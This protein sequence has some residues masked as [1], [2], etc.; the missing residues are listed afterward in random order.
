MLD[1]GR[2]LTCIFS[3]DEVSFD[4]S[5]SSRQILAGVNNVGASML[6]RLNSACINCG[7]GIF[8]P[9]LIPPPGKTCVAVMF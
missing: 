8:L 1:T 6:D 3:L 2:L 9:L 4:R 7:R 5:V